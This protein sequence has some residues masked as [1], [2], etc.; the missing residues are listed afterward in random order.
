MPHLDSVSV[1]AFALFLNSTDALLIVLS[2]PTL[3][4]PGLKSVGMTGN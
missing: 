4:I 1:G 3:C 2:K